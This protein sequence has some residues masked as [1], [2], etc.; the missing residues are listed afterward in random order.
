M[1]EQYTIK[2][3]QL[4][5]LLENVRED[6]VIE[7]FTQVEGILM[8]YHPVWYIVLSFSMKRGGKGTSSKPNFAQ[9]SAVRTA[10]P[11]DRERTATRLPRMAG[12]LYHFDGVDELRFVLNTDHTCLIKGPVNDL[13]AAGKSR[14]YGT[15]R[16]RR[17]GG[18]GLIFE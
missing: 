4:Q 8:G 3:I 1:I 17:F 10:W 9:A 7:N 11:P 18:S 5:S 16:F 2:I 15:G 12:G 14:L 13:V 6:G